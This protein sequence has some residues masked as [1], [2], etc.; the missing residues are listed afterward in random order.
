[1]FGTEETNTRAWGRAARKFPRAAENWASNVAVDVIVVM[2]DVQTS[3]APIR[4]VT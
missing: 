4:I 2:L 3:L 1:M